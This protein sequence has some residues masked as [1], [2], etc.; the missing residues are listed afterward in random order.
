MCGGIRKT[1]QELATAGSRW[2]Q[3][4]PKHTWKTSSVYL[5]GHGKGS[6][7]STLCD[8]IRADSHIIQGFRRIGRPRSLN[9]TE[10]LTILE[11]VLAFSDRGVSMVREHLAQAVE[12]FV[13]HL[14]ASRK[15]NRYRNG[16][17]GSDFIRS[18]I[19]CHGVSFTYRI[20]THKKA[21]QFK[22]T[23]GKTLAT[24]FATLEQLVKKHNI[25]G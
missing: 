9:D 22:A 2:C 7:K 3:R 25:D 17:S 11:S 4:K 23:N 8:E 1:H 6:C 10:E 12:T 13:K 20:P 19:R 15:E 14:P 24:R 16:R 18:F 21:K 5:K